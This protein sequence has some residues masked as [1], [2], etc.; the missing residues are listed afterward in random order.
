MGDPLQGDLFNVST[1]FKLTLDGMEVG[2]FASVSGLTATIDVTEYQEGGENSFT[3]KILGHT[4]F[5]NIVLRRGTTDS[6]ELWQWIYDA[7]QGKIERKAGS[8]IALARD[9]ETPVCTWN[10]FDAFPCSYRGPDFN[11]RNTLD[12]AIEE[13]E[14]SYHRFEMSKG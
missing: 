9:S 7:I 2:N 11:T 13:L 12:L 3:H 4:R 8:I 5:S 10:F 6:L 1:Y 14:L